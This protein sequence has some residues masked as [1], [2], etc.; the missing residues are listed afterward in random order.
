MTKK[1]KKTKKKIVDLEAIKQI[2]LNA[3]GIDIG[4]DEI[5]VCVPLDRV[6][7][8]VRCFGTFTKDLYKTSQWLK[9][10]GVETVAMES[11]GVL[12][13]PLYEHLSEQGFEVCLVNARH[14]KNVPGKKTDMLDCQWIQKLHTYGLL[15]GSFRPAE[16]MVQLRSLVRHRGMLV[17]YRSQH[18]QHMHKALQQMNLKLDRVVTDITGKTG[19]SIIR[20]IVDGER[21][22]EKLAAFRD[23]R[24]HRSEMEIANALV[25]SYRDDHLFTLRQAVELYDMYTQQLKHCDDEIEAKYAVIR[26]E[27]DDDLPPLPLPKRKS[28]TGNEPDFDL[29]QALYEQCGVDLTAIDGISALTGQTIISEIG[30]DMSAWDGC[31]KFCRWLGLAPA[32]KITG[33]KVIWRGTTKVVNRAAQAFRLAAQSVARSKSELGRYYRRMKSK[34]G[35]QVA[36]TA[37]AH[38]LARIVYSMLKN[39]TQ[40][41]PHELD[42][43]EVKRKEYHLKSLQKQASKLG[44]ELVKTSPA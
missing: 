38:K 25:G 29:R 24:C 35:P 31:A 2:N 42:K 7:E 37:T 20:A 12:W 13:V 26:P 8:N 32:N 36:N 17:K 6:K 18:I 14:I 39:K 4:A 30:V 19:M 33:G 16:E 5:Y 3:A 41:R 22:V 15:A 10:C 40:Y 44:F 34:H 27:F 9:E 11:T 28:K 21:D 23:G 1:R 43:Y